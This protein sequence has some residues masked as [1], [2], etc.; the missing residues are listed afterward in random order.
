MTARAKD[1]P[2]LEQRDVGLAKVKN[3]KIHDRGIEQT[4]AQ[5]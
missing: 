1:S 2:T 5:R 3:A 4:L